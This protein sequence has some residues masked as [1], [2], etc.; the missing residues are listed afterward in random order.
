MLLLPW[1]LS[2]VFMYCWITGGKKFRSRLVTSYNGLYRSRSRSYFTTDGQSVNMASATPLGPM[3]RFYFFLSFAGKL[4]CSS[5][6]GALSDERTGLQFVVQ[7]VSG[8][9]RG[10]LITIHYCLIR[11]YWAPFP[12]PLMTRRDYGGIIITHGDTCLTCI[13]SF[14]KCFHLF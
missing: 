9:S 13:T 8:Q 6:W 7:S 5:S 10:G 2:I 3:T 4:L 12:L 14:I 11:D 1:K